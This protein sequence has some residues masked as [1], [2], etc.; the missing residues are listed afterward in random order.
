MGMA[1][2]SLAKD[3]KALK[4]VSQ[5]NVNV[6]PAAVSNRT[7]IEPPYKMDLQ[8]FAK[9][10]GGSS[11]G[12]VAT[13]EHLDGYG[14]LIDSGV[15]HSGGTKPGRRLS[16]EEQLQT[17]TEA[18]ILK[19]LNKKG[20][21]SRGDTIV[22]YGT[23]PPCNPGRSKRPSRGCQKAMQDFSNDNDVN[24]LYFMKGDSNPWIFPR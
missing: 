10:S 1:G 11:K 15:S 20:T 3:G 21:V 12:H 19:E 22:I 7:I 18:K 4:A 14:H 13:W 17:H 8:K 23:K 6:K 5:G 16:F 9:K 2:K 24:N